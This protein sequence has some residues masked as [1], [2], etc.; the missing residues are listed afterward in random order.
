MSVRVIVFSSFF[1]MFPVFD[2]FPWNLCGFTDIRNKHSSP[3]NKREYLDCVCM[4]SSQELVVSPEMVTSVLSP[5]QLMGSTPS[6]RE[7]VLSGELEKRNQVRRREEVFPEHAFSGR[8]R[9]HMFGVWVM[10]EGLHREGSRTQHL[11]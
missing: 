2:M 3:T 11:S 8:W 1:D 9:W 10:G 7:H 5:D 6:T 4:L